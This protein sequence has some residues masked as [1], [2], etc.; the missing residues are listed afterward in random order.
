MPLQHL[1]QPE[2][3][4]HYSVQ[5]NQEESS[6]KSRND[7]DD[8]EKSLIKIDCI[9]DNTEMYKYEIIIS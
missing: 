9:F 2:N 6:Y 4:I 5:R 7:T 1:S 8:W 3:F